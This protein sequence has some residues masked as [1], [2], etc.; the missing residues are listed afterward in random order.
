MMKWYKN[1]CTRI[2]VSVAQICTQILSPKNAVKILLIPMKIQKEFEYAKNKNVFSPAEPTEI[3]KNI[4]NCAASMI[5]N[6]S[7]IF[8]MRSS[9]HA[10][11]IAYTAQQHAVT[12][13]LYFCFCRYKA[14]AIC[15]KITVAMPK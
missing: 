2:K 8:S 10:D 7:I 14:P 5:K 6:A 1:K 12:V 11:S 13:T 9:M 3:V 4:A 15:D